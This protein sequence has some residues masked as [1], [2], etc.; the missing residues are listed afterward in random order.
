MIFDLCA[1]WCERYGMRSKNHCHASITLLYGLLKCYRISGSHNVS[2]T[3]C[4]T[5]GDKVLI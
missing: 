1:L 3:R 2:P 5:Q 4:N